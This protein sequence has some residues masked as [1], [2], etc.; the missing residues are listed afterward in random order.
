MPTAWAV[1]GPQHDW[2]AVFATYLCL[3]CLFKLHLVKDFT[4]DECGWRHG[5]LSSLVYTEPELKDH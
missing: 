2:P 5:S 3:N 4:S 1:W